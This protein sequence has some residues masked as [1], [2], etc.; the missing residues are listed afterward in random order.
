MKSALASISIGLLLIGF[1]IGLLFTVY[2]VLA[3][4]AAVVG[5]GSLF[6]GWFLGCKIERRENGRAED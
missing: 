1:A 2:L 3:I 5:F 6:L 4:Y